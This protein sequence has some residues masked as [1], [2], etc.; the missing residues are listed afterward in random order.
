MDTTTYFKSLTAELDALKNRVRNFI[1]GAHWQTDGEW[2]ESVL[3]SL[4]RRCLPE[5]IRVGRG[6]V[7]GPNATSNQIDVLIYSANKPVLFRDG[8]LVFI[9]HDALIG[10]IEV[11]TSVNKQIFK[12]AVLK[13][14]ENADRVIPH[15]RNTKLIGLFAYDN[16]GVTHDDALRAL[17]DAA[18]GE[19]KRVVDIS[20]F[21]SDLFTRWWQLEPNRN[22]GSGRQRVD[23]WHAYEIKSMAPAYFIHNVLEFLNPESVLQNQDVWFPEEGKESRKVGEIGLK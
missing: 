19:V 9:T 3:R 14:A 20:T 21:G 1:A 16:D 5:N 2:K 10:M 15:G 23:R 17:Q 18:H 12:E 7:V 4:L 22:G 11:K 8:D 13:L 6:F